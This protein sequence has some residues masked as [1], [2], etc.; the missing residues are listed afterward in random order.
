MLA[1]VINVIIDGFG[2]LGELLVINSNIIGPHRMH[3]L[4]IIAMMIRTSVSL[5][6]TRLRCANMGKRIEILLGTGKLKR[7]KKHYV[8]VEF[9][10]FSQ[11]FDAAFAKLL[12]L[13]LYCR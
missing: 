5:S 7:S 10:H 8:R 9:T 11:G 6:V 3:N 12:W 4:R 13:Y 1:Y 2:E